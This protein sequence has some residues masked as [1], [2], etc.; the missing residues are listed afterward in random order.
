MTKDELDILDGNFLAA[1]TDVRQLPDGRIL[2]VHRLL[3]HWTL[4]I[5]ISPIGY[6]DRYCYQT[7][8][9]AVAAMTAWNGV[10]DPGGGWHRHPATG[11]RRPDGDP[12][13]EYID[14]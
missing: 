10:G 13:K 12:A 4:H 5:D 3:Y 1:Y 14:P 9:Q 6:E 11:R 8:E 2:G 7:R